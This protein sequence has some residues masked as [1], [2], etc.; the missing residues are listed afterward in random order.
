MTALL[1][2]MLKLKLKLDLDLDLDLDLALTFG[3]KRTVQEKGGKEKTG[4]CSSFD[5]R[6]L[7][8]SWKCPRVSIFVFESLEESQNRP[9]V[10]WMI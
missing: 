4:Y 5:L 2:L 8:K 7:R 9:G 3:E 6:L 1:V 10:T